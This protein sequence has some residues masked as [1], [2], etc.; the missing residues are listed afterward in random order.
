MGIPKILNIAK[1]QVLEICRS[2]IHACKLWFKNS[3]GQ[4]FSPW[5]NLSNS[6]SHALIKGHL[7]IFICFNGW[8]SN[9]KFNSQLF[10]GHNLCFRSSNKK[11]NPT[12]NILLFKSLIW[13]R[14]CALKL[15]PNIQIIIR[16]QFPSLNSHVSVGTHSFAL[17]Q[18]HNNKQLKF[19]RD[20]TCN[21]C[22]KFMF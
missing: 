7:I 16:F 10:F 3:Q 11:C 20:V 14:F 1:L 13:T 22:T 18:K 8:E 6:I 4:S 5:R 2:I 19:K 9:Y 12:L 17:F 21:Y 15:I